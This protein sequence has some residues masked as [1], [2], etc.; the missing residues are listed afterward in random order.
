MSLIER[1]TQFDFSLL[2]WIQQNLRCDFLDALCAGISVLF[3]AGIFWLAVVVVLFCIRRTRAAG[4]VLLVTLAVFL[5][6]SEL[7]LK[8]IICRER[9]CHIDDSIMLA[10]NMPSSYSFP[11]GH[12]GSS[13][14]AAGAIYHWN[15]KFGIAALVIAAVVGLSRMYLFVHFPTDVVAGMIVGLLCASLTTFVAKKINQ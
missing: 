1:I 8:N 10:I 11:S 7:G 12:T 2:Y 3:E 9:P 4:V 13:F 14:A 5:L 6:V 15:R